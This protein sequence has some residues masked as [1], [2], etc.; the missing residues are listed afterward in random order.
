MGIYIPHTGRNYGVLLA[1]KADGKCRRGAYRTSYFLAR[2][3]I[4]NERTTDELTTIYR[5][6]R[7]RDRDRER[8]RAR[9]SVISRESSNARAKMDLPHTSEVEGDTCDFSVNTKVRTIERSRKL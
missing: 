8:E 9:V 3:G 7:S 1:R 4:V 5:N 2:S 6:A